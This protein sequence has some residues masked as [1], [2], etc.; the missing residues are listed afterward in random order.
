MSTGDLRINGMDAESESVS[1][2][3]LHVGDILGVS[4][5]DGLYIV[6]EVKNDTI[7]VEKVYI[8]NNIVYTIPLPRINTRYYRLK[9]I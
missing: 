3:N 8:D 1:G 5:G 6:G 2:I 7:Y 4:G 9:N